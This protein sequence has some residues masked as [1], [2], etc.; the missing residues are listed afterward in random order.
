MAEAATKKGMSG[1]HPIGEFPFDPVRIECKRCGRSGRY[2]KARLIE[3]FGGERLVSGGGD[4]N[5]DHSGTVFHRPRRRLVQDL[6]P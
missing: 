3:R 2:A 6:C 4:F 1:S 5:A